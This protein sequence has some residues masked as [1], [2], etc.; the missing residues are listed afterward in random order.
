MQTKHSRI[1]VMY[2]A[3]NTVSTGIFDG[4]TAI[5]EQIFQVEACLSANRPL[6]S[7]DILACLD[8][9]GINLSRL[10]AVCVP[11]TEQKESSRSEPL[12]AQAIDMAAYISQQLNI[13]VY[14]IPAEQMPHMP[15]E[16]SDYPGD[17]YLLYLAAHA[18]FMMK[19]RV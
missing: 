12:A 7:R 6:I 15:G 19:N 18:Q 3:K 5:F 10:E 17:P 4:Q 11:G 1:L 13:P 14:F 8:E 16:R 9:E 2:A